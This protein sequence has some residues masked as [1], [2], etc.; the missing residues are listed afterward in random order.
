MKIAII[1]AGGKAGQAILAEALQRGLDTTA[2]V[3]NTVPEA[4][5]AVIKKDLFALTREDLQYFDTVIDAFAVWDEKN[6]HQ[7]TDSLLHL[8]EILKGSKTKLIVVGG[9]GSLYTDEGKTT[10]LW[11]TPDFPA[12]YLP[13]AKAMS[14]ALA[15][16]RKIN[17]VNWLYISP[18]AEFI[19][20]GERTGNYVQAGEIFTLN[21]AG[22]SAI[23]YRDYAIGL[24]DE[25]I[26]NQHNKERISL[27]W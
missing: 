24:V 27:R 11:Q 13:L 6:F 16:L 19:A 18:A 9:A 3:R 4:A 12:G 23:S 15:E 10:Q 5:A 20:D 14:Q 26:S 1:G 22:R 25:V 8:A 21:E 17:D 7:H 2:I